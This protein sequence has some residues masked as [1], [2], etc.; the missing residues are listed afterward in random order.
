MIDDNYTVV[1]DDLTTNRGTNCERNQF[2]PGHP[3]H[4][5]PQRPVSRAEEKRQAQ[6]D[7]VPDH[8]THFVVF[9]RD[10]EFFRKTIAE[11][12]YLYPDRVNTSETEG[13]RYVTLKPSEYLEEANFVGGEVDV[14]FCKRRLTQGEWKALEYHADQDSKEDSQSEPDSSQQLRGKSYK[15][16]AV[17]PDNRLEWDFDFRYFRYT[18]ILPTILTTKYHQ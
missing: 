7:A 9:N 6:L 13:I 11:Y 14:E 8:P 12:I 3:Y 5:P 2:P 15:L 16:G 18:E 17:M 1:E 10:V 4:I